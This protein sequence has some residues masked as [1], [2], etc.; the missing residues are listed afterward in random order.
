MVPYLF[1]GPVADHCGQPV[2]PPSLVLREASE[3]YEI[4]TK[5]SRA[6]VTA[7]TLLDRTGEAPPVAAQPRHKLSDKFESE[8]AARYGFLGF[9]PWSL[10]DR[11]EFVGNLVDFF[12][13]KSL[14][15]GL[16][17]FPS[18]VELENCRD[19]VDRRQALPGLTAV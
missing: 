8:P 15:L 16:Q 9:E 17:P 7:V 5:Q 6:E 18:N 19:A 2:A 13:Y 14:K 1:R 11:D 12:L 4:R 3:W 10:R